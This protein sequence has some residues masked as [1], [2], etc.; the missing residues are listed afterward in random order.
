[1]QCSNARCKNQLPK[2]SAFA[3]CNA[4]V[5]R[6]V[7][8]CECPKEECH[9]NYFGVVPQHGTDEWPHASDCTCADCEGPRKAA[10]LENDDSATH[11]GFCLQ[12]DPSCST[13]SKRA[14]V[15]TSLA[16]AG[17]MDASSA[18]CFDLT[19]DDVARLVKAAPTTGHGHALANVLAVRDKSINVPQDEGLTTNGHVGI[20]LDSGS[21]DPNFSLNAA[22][23]VQ[24][25]RMAAM[26]FFILKQGV[27]TLDIHAIR[28]CLDEFYRKT[29]NVDIY[30]DHHARA[31]FE[32]ALTPDGLHVSMPE[33]THAWYLKTL[34]PIPREQLRS[35]IEI[36]KATTDRACVP[37]AVLN[38][39]AGYGVAVMG[40]LGFEDL[41]GNVE[42]WEFAGE[43]WN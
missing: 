8:L 32:P 34:R 27:D 13:P 17:V 25:T 18:H 24:A 14:S 1:M 36:F 40:K 31:V 26:K 38:E 21:Y 4:C 6:W 10:T 33:A 2:N 20:L 15:T 35:A 19:G 12:C 28:E 22:T 39:L 23:C 16:M 41:D 37:L 3:E 11:P 42:D 9:H 5:R 30:C 43:A 29:K 7:T